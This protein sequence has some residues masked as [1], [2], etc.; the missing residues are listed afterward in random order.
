[1]DF[2]WLLDWFW[3]DFRAKLGSKLGSKLAPK[4]EELG[5]QDD[6]KK[7]QESGDAVVRGGHARVTQGN[8]VL[9]PKKSLWDF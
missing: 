4:S 7:Y 5:Y 8:L 6:A 1:M 2:G 9:A 3:I